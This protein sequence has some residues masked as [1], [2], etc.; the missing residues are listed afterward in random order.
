MVTKMEEK[1]NKM[2]NTTEYAYLVFLYG[3]DLVDNVIYHCDQQKG[4]CVH[5]PERYLEAM[6][7][8]VQFFNRYNDTNLTVI[9][10]P[11]VEHLVYEDEEGGYYHQ[12][13]EKK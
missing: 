12:E 3:K 4:D 2:K 8:V 10:P 13:K 9:V 5:S 6:T 11:L 7:K 1:E